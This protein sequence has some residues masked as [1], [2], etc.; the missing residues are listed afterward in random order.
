M[1]VSPEERAI[2]LERKTLQAADGL[3]AMADYQAFGVSTRLKTERL[4]AERMAK[5]ASDKVTPT[6]QV[7]TT[8]RKKRSAKT[9]ARRQAVNPRLR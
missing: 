2:R 8:P 4:K 9:N 1:T 5:L 7:V 3:K 6:I